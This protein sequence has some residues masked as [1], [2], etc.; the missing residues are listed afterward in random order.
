MTWNADDF[1]KFKDLPASEIQNLIE[2]ERPMYDPSSEYYEEDETV[3]GGEVWEA[4][5]DYESRQIEGLGT[6]TILDSVGGGEGGG[7]HVHKI[8][9]VT[10][11]QGDHRFFQKQGWYQSYDGTHWDGDLF[12]V[13]PVQRTVTVWEKVKR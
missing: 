2:A 7:E 12:E 1:Q 4:W 3:S 11:P 9:R 13:R 5:Y 8:V 6:A 10:N